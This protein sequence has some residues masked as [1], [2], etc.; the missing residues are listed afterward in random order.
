MVGYNGVWE[1]KP[2]TMAEGWTVD[3]IDLTKKRHLYWSGGKQSVDLS[4]P[5]EEAW[6]ITTVLREGREQDIREL[7]LGRVEEM[8]P[9]LPLPR[10]LKEMWATYF[11]EVEGHGR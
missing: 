2:R 9:R 7:P 8:L 6:W 10:F 3:R 11:R 4:D 5:E 1:V